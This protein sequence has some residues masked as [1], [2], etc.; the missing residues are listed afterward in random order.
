MYFQI[1]DF[2]GPIY[3]ER[4]KSLPDF[5]YNRDCGRLVT[6]E[7]DKS[8]IGGI[9]EWKPLSFEDMK[10]KANNLDIG[11]GVNQINASHILL[12]TKDGNEVNVQNTLNILIENDELIKTGNFFDKGVI[13]AESLNLD[14]LNGGLSDRSIMYYDQYHYIDPIPYAK[15]IGEAIDYALLRNG[16]QIPIGQTLMLGNQD[17]VFSDSS[18][19]DAIQFLA[20]KY[21][22][23]ANADTISCTYYAPDPTGKTHCVES[24]VQKAMTDLANQ[25]YTHRIIDHLDVQHDWGRCGQYLGTCGHSEDEE[26]DCC[27]NDAHLPLKFKHIRACEIRTT[28][29]PYMCM[30]DAEPEMDLQS[31]LYI[32][33]TMACSTWPIGSIFITVNKRNPRELIGYGC[34]TLIEGKFLLGWSQDKYTVP[35]QISNDQVHVYNDTNNPSYM[36]VYMWKRVN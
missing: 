27:L 10:I 14:P 13:K 29:G 31:L 5:Q 11:F 33:M 20:D 35:G 8:Y 34:W 3:A 12:R 1:G 32:M 4:L 2:K 22:A 7:K 25:F 26:C 28:V 15:P 24:T 21:D 23:G 30:P 17:A 18:I 16:S 36:I 19:F 9:T 6:I